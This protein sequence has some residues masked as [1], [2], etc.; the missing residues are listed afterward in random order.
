MFDGGLL[1]R[2]SNPSA[3]AFETMEPFRLCVALT[4][5]AIYMV[6]ISLTSF[7]RRPVVVSG[8]RDLAALGLGVSGLI[9]VG[10]V[11]LLL[12]S[13]PLDATGTVWIFVAVLYCLLL[14]LGVL[15]TSPRIVVYN[16]TADQLRPALADA[17]EELDAG[18]RWAGGSVALPKLHVECFLEEHASVRN[19]TLVATAAQQSYAGWRQLEKALRSRLRETVEAAPSAWGLGVLLTALVIFARMGWLVY[20]KPQEI[21]QGFL[22]MMQF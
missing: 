10:P 21:S 12:P 3:G 18:A 9:L 7:M 13:L 11:E 19:V 2:R 20:T 15:L 1:V 5:L 8:A 22:E 17:I 6:A 14:T 16:V 4:P